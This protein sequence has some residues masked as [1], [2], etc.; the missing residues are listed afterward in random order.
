[1]FTFIQSINDKVSFLSLDVT[2]P[3]GLFNPRLRLNYVGDL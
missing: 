3:L 2:I 1:M